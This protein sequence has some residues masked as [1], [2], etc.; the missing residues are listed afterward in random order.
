MSYLK[1]LP[2]ST[3]KI[4]QSFIRDIQVYTKDAAIVEASI[5]IAHKLGLRVVAEGVETPEQLA[6]LK[7]LNCDFAQGYLYSKPLQESE[8]IRL[9]SERESKKSD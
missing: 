2:L 8:L 1:Q 4:D 5:Y 3:L 6:F 9:L 7:R